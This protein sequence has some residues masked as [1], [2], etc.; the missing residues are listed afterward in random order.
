MVARGIRPFSPLDIAGLKLWLK[1][2]SLSL[3]DGDAI[4][5]WTDSS[6]SGNNGSGG[7]FGNATYKTSIQNSLPIAR[8]NGTTSGVDLPII[9]SAQPDTIL[10]VANQ[11][12][13]STLGCIV[14]TRSGSSQRMRLNIT[15]GFLTVYAGNSITDATDHSGAFHVFTG[16]Y[17]GASSFSYVDGTQVASGDANT[18]SGGSLAIGTTE[19]SSFLTGDIAEV[20]IYNTALSGTNRGSVESYLKTKWATP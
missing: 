10:V 17:N 19:G 5:S 20:L 3:N 1:A 14:E 7:T 6:G 4:T 15:T 9:V 2:D 8:F 13:K 16:V 12:S 11:T 18:N